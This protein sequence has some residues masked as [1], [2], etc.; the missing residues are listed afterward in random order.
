MDSLKKKKTGLGLFFSDL[1]AMASDGEIVM[2]GN[3]TE[4]G[5]RI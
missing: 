3:D 4:V 1:K 2:T 5:K